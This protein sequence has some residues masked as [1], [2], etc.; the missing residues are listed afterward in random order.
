MGIPQLKKKKRLW[1]VLLA[2]RL[3]TLVSTSRHTAA[4]RIGRNGDL[5]G[6]FIRQFCQ[7]S[8]EDRGDAC[9]RTS[10][11]VAH[12]VASRVSLN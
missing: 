10:L 11:L 6:P 1:T 7:H 8:C 5:E 4:T 12:A 3:K 9:C 2:T